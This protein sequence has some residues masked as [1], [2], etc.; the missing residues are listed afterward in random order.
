MVNCIR[1][2]APA[3]QHWVRARL[4]RVAR[5]FPPRPTPPFAQAHWRKVSG[6]ETLLCGVPYTF[7]YIFVNACALS[8]PRARATALQLSLFHKTTDCFRMLYDFE[9]TIHVS[10]YHVHTQI[11]VP[12]VCTSV[13]FHLMT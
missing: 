1:T 10:L 5:P 6:A 8:K 3:F 7:R 4:G 9:L 12:R 2:L 13:P 11:L